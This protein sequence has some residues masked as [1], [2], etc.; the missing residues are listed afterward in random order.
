[1]EIYS[2]NSAFLPGQ[3]NNIESMEYFGHVKLAAPGR[4]LSAAG[5]VL[6][7]GKT[8]RGVAMQIS[9]DSPTSSAERRLILRHRS[10]SETFF[11]K[12]FI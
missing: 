9:D 6:W 11:V 10:R 2:D 8:T 4:F 7:K 3:H 12:D 1:M 5:Q